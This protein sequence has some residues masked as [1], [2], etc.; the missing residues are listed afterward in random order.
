[1]FPFQQ[2][3]QLRQVCCG[4]GAGAHLPG[5][6]RQTVRL[7]DNQQPGVVQQGTPSLQPVDG[8][9]QQIVVVADLDHAL[10]PRDLPQIPVVPAAP[11]ARTIRGTMR[12]NADQSAVKAAELRCLIQIQ[13]SA[14]G[15]KRFELVLVFF[16]LPDSFQTTGK[17]DV[18]DKSLLAFADGGV[19]RPIDH[20]ILQ[21]YTGEKGKIFPANGILKRDGRGRDGDGL[22]SARRAAAAEQ[23]GRG[24]IGVCFSDAGAGVAERDT[25]MPHGIYH[26]MTE[27][28]LLLPHSHSV[29]RKKAAKEP[30]R[31]CVSILLFACD[32]ASLPM[33]DGKLMRRGF[34]PRR[35][36]SPSTAI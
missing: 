22:C 21:Q 29:F 12:R 30:L 17:P 24:E 27:G 1:M 20:A 32:G 6:L 25:S 3:A 8:V 23:D 13:L 16:F 5:G 34:G 31:L 15:E 36:D 7:V 9:R 4:D 35:T 10:A 11:G 33:A 2:A 19:E 18:A 28:N 26:K 14:Q